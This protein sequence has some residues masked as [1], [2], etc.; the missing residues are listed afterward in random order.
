MDGRALVLLLGVDSYSTRLLREVRRTV[1]ADVGEMGGGEMSD[2][3]REAGGRDNQSGAGAP[4]CESGLKEEGG[5][6]VRIG[7]SV[8]VDSEG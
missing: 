1:A 2:V 7:W 6:A 8:R 5:A 3:R 4:F